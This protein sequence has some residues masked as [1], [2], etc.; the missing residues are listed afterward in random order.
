MLWIR[1]HFIADTSEQ[2]TDIKMINIEK[3]IKEVLDELAFCPAGFEA[4]ARNEAV[5][6]QDV[7][8][9]LEHSL[10]TVDLTHEALVNECRLARNL[11]IAAVCV[12]PYYADEA[13]Q[14]L[15]GSSVA[16]CTAVGFPSA[17]MSTEGK[18]ADVRACVLSGASE[19]DLAINVAAVKSGKFDVVEQD[20]RRTADA[21][22]GKVIIKAVFEHGSYND[23]E[24]EQ[25]LA[26]IKRS[27]AQ[28]LKIQN[29]T[30]G[31]GAKAEDIRFVQGILGS[32]IKIKIDGG[33]KTLSQALEL[34][35]A[36]ASRIGL[37]ATKAVVEEVG[38]S[39]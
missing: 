23:F 26:I 13:V 12:A 17:L 20:F 39:Y 37:T 15:G 29:M 22:Q 30:S 4:E 18:V 24:K 2:G 10:L 34:I 9:M 3:A 7:P 38:A 27:G 8:K 31:H 16:V 5:N 11:Q 32:G 1:F 25:V 21:A 36:G 14:L 35:G 28:F 6:P 33:V 19:I